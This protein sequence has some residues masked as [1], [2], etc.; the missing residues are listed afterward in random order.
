MLKV[1]AVIVMVFVAGT[2]LGAAVGWCVPPRHS[3]LVIPGAIGAAFILM[4]GIVCGA[5]PFAPH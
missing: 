2:I 3:L 1:T 4:A 5:L